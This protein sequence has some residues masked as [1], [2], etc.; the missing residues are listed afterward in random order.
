MRDNS[1]RIRSLHLMGLAIGM[2]VE[3]RDVRVGTRFEGWDRARL[4]EHAQ[5]LAQQLAIEDRS[6][7]EDGE[8]VG[9]SQ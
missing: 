1:N 3:R 8:A 5:V 4:I 7:K 9:A 6:E 2:F